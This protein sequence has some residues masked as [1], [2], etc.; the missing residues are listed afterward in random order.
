MSLL[1]MISDFMG[2]SKKRAKKR[3]SGVPESE[4]RELEKILK[5]IG[6]AARA[7]RI[8]TKTFKR[9]M[10]RLQVIRSH[11]QKLKKPKRKSKK[12]DSAI[13]V[14]VEKG[15][16]ES[17]RSSTFGLGPSP[18]S[19]R[20]GKNGYCWRVSYA[21]RS[22]GTGFVIMQEWTPGDVKKRF[23]SRMPEHK[24]LGLEQIDTSECK[25]ETGRS[26]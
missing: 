3:L 13:P 6:R 14:Y 4:M 19:Q 9:D 22:G 20:P 10:R 16:L 12:R 21:T 7:K 15:R 26:K 23:E 1:D 11:I 2:K 18:K 5:R 17:P 24:I 25:L 8:N